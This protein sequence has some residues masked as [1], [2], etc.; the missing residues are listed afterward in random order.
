MMLVETR[1]PV[2]AHKGDIDG[3]ESSILFPMSHYSLTTMIYIQYIQ[4]H[5]TR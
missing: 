2:L 4:I 5:Q 3:V 1:E